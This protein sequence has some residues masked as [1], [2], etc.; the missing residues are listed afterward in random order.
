MEAE[1]T[2]NEESDGNEEHILE[3][4]REWSCSFTVAENVLEL[5]P[6]VMWKATPVTEKVGYL[7]EEVF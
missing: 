2:A 1:C 4:W 6:V 3:S 7:A 5:C